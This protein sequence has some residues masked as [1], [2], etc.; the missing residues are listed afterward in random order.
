MELLSPLHRHGRGG[1]KLIIAGP[2][3]PLGA[4]GAKAISNS[5]PPAFDRL[6]DQLGRKRKASA[7]RLALYC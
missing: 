5:G 1:G 7:W 2:N 6:F 3:P 4:A